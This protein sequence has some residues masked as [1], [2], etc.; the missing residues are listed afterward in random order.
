MQSTVLAIVGMGP[1][2]LTVLE[3]VAEHAHRLPRGVRLRID[4]FDR[5][6]CG[7]GVHLSTQPDH[8]LINTLASQVTMFAPESVAGGKG[9]VSLVEWATLAG[10]RHVGD[11]FQRAPNDVGLSMTEIDHFPRRLL[12][13]YMSWVYR[14]VLE[15]LPAKVEVAHHPELVV[16]LIERDCGFDVIT[17]A[18][19]SRRADF[20]VLA[21]GHGVRRPTEEDRLHVD[22]VERNARRNRNLA[23]YATP[24]PVE[25]LDEISASATVA[26]QGFGLTAHDAISAL[27]LG[28]GGRYEENDG[29]LRYH[30]SGHEPKIVLFS[31]NCLPFAAR[32]VNQKGLSG[33]HDAK[34]LTPEAIAAIRRETLATTGDARIDFER[35]VQPLV[36]KEMAYAYRQAE[37]G[38]A[39]ESAGFEPTSEELRAID[40]ILHPLDGIIFHTSRAFRA[41]FNRLVDDDLR[42]AVKGNL[43]SPVKA[44]CD[45]LR[46][47]REAIRAAVE[48]GGLTPESHRY[49]IETFNGIIN[50]V[51]FGP[52]KRR[53]FEQVALQEAG[54]IRIG[55]GPGAQ[56]RIDEEEARFFIETRYESEVEKVHADVLVIAR[57]DPYS[58]LTDSSPLTAALLA[59]G[60]IRPYRNGD[61]HPSG[62]DIDTALHPIDSSGKACKR[63]WALG[64]PVEG[65]HYYTHALPRPMIASRQTLDAERCVLEM[66]DVIAAS[67]EAAPTTSR[68][69]AP[70]VAMQAQPRVS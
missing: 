48:Y 53:N 27:T 9:G 55:G 47:T 39:V 58:P 64:F 15:R 23:F 7:E 32:G 35:V 51:S 12:G 38:R 65:P 17:Q 43:A 37:Q 67:N 2:G 62:I 68:Y 29:E 14:R 61:F 11:R 16:D 36:I 20:V 18:G 22:F 5:G 41:F 30:A 6:A 52:P 60:M 69:P 63:L 45:V 24:Y 56:V 33:R 31:R 66:L 44:A 42:E 50:R 54:L 21:T 25:R 3:R 19:R 8:L 49:F 34:F 10:Y 1:R 46:D 40:A 4:L 59:H 57:L 70:H 13:E 26:I 28:R